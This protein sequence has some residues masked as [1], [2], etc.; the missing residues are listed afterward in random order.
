V[1]TKDRELLARLNAVGRDL[2]A[3]GQHVG[4]LLGQPLKQDGSGGLSARDLRTVGYRLVSLAG[5]V[6][7]LGV[8][9]A[10]W[11]DDLDDLTA[12]NQ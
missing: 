6:T 5:D 4:A 8:D 9:A 7:T 2:G 11:A 12:R 1:I 10:H 3:I